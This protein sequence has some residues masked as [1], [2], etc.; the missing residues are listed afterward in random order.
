MR[1]GRQFSDTREL[2]QIRRLLRAD[3]DLPRRADSLP[4]RPAALPGLGIRN[5][6]AR[7]V[8][9]QSLRTR[10][11]HFAVR[12]SRLQARH[13]VGGAGAHHRRDARRGTPRRRRRLDR[14][15]DGI[16]LDPCE[17]HLTPAEDRSAGDAVADE[18]GR[19]SPGRDVLDPTRHP[20]Q[21]PSRKRIEKTT[22]RAGR[23]RGGHHD[24][25]AA[26][27][28]D[29]LPVLG[30]LLRMLGWQSGEK[31]VQVVAQHHRRQRFAAGRPGRDQ[32]PHSLGI[33]RHPSRI[34]ALR[35]DQPQSRG[36]SGTRRAQDRDT[37]FHPA[38]QQ[39]E[40]L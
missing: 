31:A 8:R 26:R 34:R 5:E 40:R 12:V 4:H 39:L 17:L 18:P 36:A 13:D 16:L 38:V 20:Q 28:Q 25:R 15:D 33:A 11:K 24:G 21:G 1:E 30:E 37:P 32:V 29:P 6:D 23:T 19:F 14:D 9:P 35:G 7:D 27:P 22:H 3:E 10:E 2:T